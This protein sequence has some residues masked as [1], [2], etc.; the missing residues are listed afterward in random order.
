[1]AITGGVPATVERLRREGYDWIVIDTPPSRVEDSIKPSIVASDFVLIPI[2]TTAFDITAVAT[3]V[4]LCKQENKP[5]AFVLNRVEARSRLTEQATDVLRRDGNVLDAWISNR[6]SYRGA[7]T[8]GMTGAESKDTKARE[9]IDALW[10]SV[11]QLAGS[12]VKNGGTR[13]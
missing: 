7:I 4:A 13:G 3:V 9:E 11:R 6:E 2:Q 12:A 5:F 8:D 1:M 10:Q